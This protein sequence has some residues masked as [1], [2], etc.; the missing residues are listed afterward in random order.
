MIPMSSVLWVSF[1][2]KI[3]SL[4]LPLK[5]FHVDRSEIH[6]QHSWHQN[7]GNAILLVLFPDYV[8]IAINCFQIWQALQM[9]VSSK[10][11]LF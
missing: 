7:I 4:F 1:R 8:Y 6:R 3:P 2:E 11:F 10:V 9:S 5:Q